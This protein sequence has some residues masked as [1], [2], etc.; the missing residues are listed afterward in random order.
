MFERDPVCNKFMRRNE[1]WVV[2]FFFFIF[3]EKQTSSHSK[4][5][6]A[7]NDFEFF[8][9]TILQLE[10]EDCLRKLGILVVSGIQCLDE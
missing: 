5:G 3:C 7:V 6:V 1:E 8:T 9:G 2:F 4:V 10:L